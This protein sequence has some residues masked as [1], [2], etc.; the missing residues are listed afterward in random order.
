M[1]ITKR[2]VFFYGS[3]FIGVMT[4]MTMCLS[5]TKLE[6][7]VKNFTRIKQ[8]SILSKDYKNNLIDYNLDYSKGYALFDKEKL[9]K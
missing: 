6:G 2:D 4:L 9:H 7:K 5:T 3:M 1:K 8:N